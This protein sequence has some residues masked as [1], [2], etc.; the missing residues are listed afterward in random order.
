MFLPIKRRV[1]NDEIKLNCYSLSKSIK[2]ITHEMHH[3]DEMH[4]I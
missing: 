1:N 3:I 4:K 2:V